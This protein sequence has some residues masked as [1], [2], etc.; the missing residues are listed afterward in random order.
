MHRMIVLLDLD[1]FKAFKRA[2]AANDLTVSQVVRAMVRD[3]ISAKP[4]S[5]LDLS[6]PKASKKGGK[7]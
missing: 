2:C 6:V 3:Y 5:A 7:P 1:L 4:Q